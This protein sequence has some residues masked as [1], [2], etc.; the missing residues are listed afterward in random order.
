MVRGVTRC[1]EAAGAGRAEVRRT[2]CHGLPAGLTDDVENESDTFTRLK[3]GRQEEKVA[4]AKRRTRWTF[5]L[6]RARP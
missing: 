3:G 6:K 5:F 1:R 2:Y 4:L